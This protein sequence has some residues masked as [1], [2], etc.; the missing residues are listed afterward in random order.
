MRKII[1]FAAVLM[2]S[3]ISIVQAEWKPD[4]SNERSLDVAKAIVNA[5][6]ED[7]GM[8][9]FF[10]GAIAYAVFPKVGKGGLGIGGA[11]GKGLVIQGDRTIGETSLSQISIGF[12]WGGQVYSEFIF[13]K[14]QNA[15]GNFTRGNFELGAQASAVAVTV[16]ASADVAY[17]NGVAIFTVVGGGLMYEA[18]VGGQKFKYKAL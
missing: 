14:D 2:L 16:G 5:K 15:L 3:L 6:S 7:P 11:H 8:Q 18:S 17:N 10:D 4:T 12:Q 1:F 13:F 9:K